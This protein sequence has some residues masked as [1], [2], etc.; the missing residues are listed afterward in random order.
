MTLS[1][2]LTSL[3]LCFSR[4]QGW[5]FPS[6]SWVQSPGYCCPFSPSPTPRRCQATGCYC[7]GNR[8]H[9][10]A[11]AR[12]GLFSPENR[13]SLFFAQVTCKRYS[14][15]TCRYRRCLWLLVGKEIGQGLAGVGGGLGSGLPC[16]PN[17]AAENGL[18]GGTAWLG[19]WPRWSRL[20]GSVGEES[21]G[22]SLTLLE[23]VTLSAGPAL[24]STEPYCVP[25]TQFHP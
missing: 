3:G 7:L 13:A 14:S 6:A 24:P 25:P 20:I 9:G 21:A 15:L 12:V 22:P 19:V 1:Q 2:S 23:A 17:D 18:L 5:V 4:G 11:G 16:P 8:S 10:A